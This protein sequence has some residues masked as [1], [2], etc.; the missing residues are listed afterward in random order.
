MARTIAFALSARTMYGWLPRDKGDGDLRRLVGCGHVF[1]VSSAV[2]PRALMKVR[3]RPRV[4]IN[5]TRSV[6]L[7]SERGVSASFP[8]ACHHLTS[9]SPF[10]SGRNRPA[11]L[12]SHAG[13]QVSPVF[14][15]AQIA[16]A[17]RL[18][19]AIAATLSGFVMIRRPSQSSPASAFRR[20]E[21]TPIAPR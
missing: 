15:M 1:G 14:S 9:P 2:S 18:A 4:P 11:V 7:R 20:A 17:M 8:S 21:I 6:A 3:V 16:R 5:G 10:R 12:S 19:N 13:R